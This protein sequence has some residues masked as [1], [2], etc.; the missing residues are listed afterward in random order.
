MAFDFSKS[1]FQPWFERLMAIAAT[2]NFGLVIFDYTYVPWRDFYLKRIP[3]VT[4]IYDPIKGI[5]PH[6]ETQQYLNVVDA[7][8]QQVSQ[9][10]LRS[11]QTAALLE[12]LR[13]LS[14]DTIETNPFALANKSGRLERRNKNATTDA[15]AH[16]QVQLFGISSAVLDWLSSLKPRLILIT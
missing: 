14:N 9:T 11:P 7:L 1:H 10:G 13:R 16:W 6:R 4:T 2:V 8:E 5:E 12:Q 15:V 3:E